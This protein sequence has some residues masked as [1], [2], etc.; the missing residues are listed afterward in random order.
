M[1]DFLFLLSMKFFQIPQSVYAV[2]HQ[3]ILRVIR[4]HH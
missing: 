3:L 2:Y 4:L 1:V